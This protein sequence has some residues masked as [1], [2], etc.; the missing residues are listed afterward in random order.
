MN[1]LMALLTVVER[2]DKLLVTSGKLLPI[3]WDIP[4]CYWRI[5]CGH[6]CP[7]VSDCWSSYR[8]GI[9]LILWH[10]MNTAGRLSFNP[11][12]AILSS[13]C[14]HLPRWSDWPGTALSPSLSGPRQRGAGQCCPPPGRGQSN[15]S[16]V[17]QCQPHLQLGQL[18]VSQHVEKNQ[19]HVR[20]KA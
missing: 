20:N 12:Q 10:V 6:S 18:D 9:H 4:V 5:Q 3:H 1:T 13:V 2:L 7:G 15:V 17:S 14:S 19:R 8:S 11:R 16:R